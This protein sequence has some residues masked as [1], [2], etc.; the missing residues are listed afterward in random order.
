MTADV[1]L[2]SRAARRIAEILKSEPEPMMLR[3]AVTGGGCSGF[4]YNFAL[5]D[6]RTDDDLVLERDG[7]TVLIDPM[8]LDFLK[9]AEIDFTDDLIGAAFKVNN[10]N[11]QSSCGC[12]TSFSV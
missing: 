12:G 3:L 7:A 8:S 6:T 11:A 2:S 5:D 9:G 1:T 10:P 4:Q